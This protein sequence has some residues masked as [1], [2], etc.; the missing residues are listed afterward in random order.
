MNYQLFVIQGGNNPEYDNDQGKIKVACETIDKI[1]EKEEPKGEKSFSLQ[2]FLFYTG[3]I[4]F[5]FWHILKC[6]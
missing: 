6:N 1:M 2:E 4:L 5:I 3:M